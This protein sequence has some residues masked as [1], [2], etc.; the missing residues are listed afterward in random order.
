MASASAKPLYDALLLAHGDLPPKACLRALAHASRRTVA[1]DGA[2]DRLSRMGLWPDFILGDLDSVSTSTLKSAARRRITVLPVKE[3][4]TSDLEK[5]LRFCQSRGWKRVAVAGILGPRLDHSLNALSIFAKYSALE[6]TLLTSQSIGRVVHGHTS[7]SCA[8][9]PGLRLSL[10][11]A[12]VARGV[13]LSG[14]SWPL[15]GRTLRQD[16][17]VSLSNKAVAPVVSMCQTS[18][19]SIFIVQRSRGQ[20][21]LA[22]DTTA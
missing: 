5:G 22:C 21:A 15:R 17:L 7:L 10:M 13:T 18:G 19:C 14:V 12:P 9:R 11:P 2:A 3:Q 8:V 1:L 16:G 20:I 4:K 6:V